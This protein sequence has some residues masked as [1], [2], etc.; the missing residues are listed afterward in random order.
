MAKKSFEE[1]IQEEMPDFVGEVLGLTVQDL[2]NR[3]AAIAKASHEND[4]NQKNDEELNQAKAHARELG[5][6]YAEPRKALKK[7]TKYI[8]KLIQE[9]GGA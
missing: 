1:K 9:K 2:N 5:Q 7:K 8:V 3:L 4:E 6:T